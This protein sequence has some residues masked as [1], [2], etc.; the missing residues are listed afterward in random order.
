MFVGEV[1]WVALGR[2]DKSEILPLFA[3]ERNSTRVLQLV[4]SVMAEMEVLLCPVK[5]PSAGL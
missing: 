2:S 1:G 5:C 3:E 4:E